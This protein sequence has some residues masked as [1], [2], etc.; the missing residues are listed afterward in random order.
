M[1]IELHTKAKCCVFQGLSHYRCAIYVK[2]VKTLTA[3]SILQKIVDMMRHPSYTEL[4]EI[5]HAGLASEHHGLVK[6]QIHNY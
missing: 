1:F 2:M 4:Y 5:T 6:F 3:W